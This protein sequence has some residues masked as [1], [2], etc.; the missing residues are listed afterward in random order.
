MK[1]LPA[2]R[3]DGLCVDCGVRGAETNDGRFCRKCLRVRIRKEN[4]IP[5]TPYRTPDQK[6]AR[7]FDADNR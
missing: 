2:R 3:K 7:D 1:S 6:Q 5:W 4:Y